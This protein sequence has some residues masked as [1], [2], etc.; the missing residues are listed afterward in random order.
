[1]LPS[2]GGLY[3]QDARDVFFIQVVGAALD[4]KTEIETKARR[5]MYNASGNSRTAPYY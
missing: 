1:V 5:E 3:D 2:D 4:E